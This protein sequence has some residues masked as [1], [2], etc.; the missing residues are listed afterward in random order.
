MRSRVLSAAAAALALAVFSGG[1]TLPTGFTEVSYSGLSNATA[2]A[3]APDGRLFVCQQGGQLRI[4]KNGALLATP[5]V[6]LSVDPMGERGLLGVAFDPNFLLNQYVYVYYTV[7]GSPPHN[8]LARLTA[9]GDV[10]LAGSQVNLLEL[11]NLSGATNHNGG[12]I[13]F[14][15]DGKL[16]VAVGDNANGSNS[17]T[18]GNLLGKVLRVG[19]PPEALIPTDNP[20]FNDTTGNNRA[21]WTLGLRNPF[22]FA[23]H[24]DTGVI[25]INDV[26][27]VTWEEINVG[28]AGANYGWPDCEGDCSPPD[29]EFT[30]PFFFYPHS[31]GA[32]SIAGGDFYAPDVPQ[33]PASYVGKYFYADYCAGWIRYV[34]PASGNPSATTFATGISSPVDVHV[35]F[36]G[37]LYYIARGQGR[38]YKV[39]YTGTGDPVVTE[40]PQS[41]LISTGHPVT[42]TVSATGDAP[43]SYQ[44]QREGA[45][46]GGATS[47]SYTIASVVIGDDG[48]QFRCVV[49][50]ASGDDTSAAATLSVTTNQPPVATITAPPAGTTYAAGDTINYS[51]TGSDPETGALPGSA[52]TWWVNF[53]HDTHFHPFLPPTTGSATGAFTIPTV[54]E[55]SPNVW[56]RL[57][58]SVKDPATLTD[59]K[60]VDVIP[61]TSSLTLG[62]G[63]TGLQLT[64]DGQPFTAPQ[65]VVSVENVTRAIGAPSPQSSGGNT[66]HFQSWSDG[67]SQTHDIATPADDTTYTASFTTA[68]PTNTPTPSRTPTPTR[69]PTRTPTPTPTTTPGGTA[70][71]SIAPTSGAAAGGTPVTVSGSGFASGATLAIGGVPASGVVVVGP[72]SLTASAPALVAGTLNDV[73]VDN[74][75]SAPIGTLANAWFADFSDVPSSNIF[76]GDIESI[77]RASVTAGCGGGNYCPANLVTRAQM[78]VFLL[79]GVHGGGYTPPACSGTVFADVPCPSGLNVDWINQLAAEGITG[80]CGGGN[81]CPGSPLTRAQMAVFLLL[82][83]HGSSYEPPACSGT[84]FDD[85]P[86][87]SGPNVNWINQL[88]AEGITVGCGGG[89]YCPTA[90]TPRGQMSTF[91]VRTFGLGPTARPARPVRRIPGARPPGR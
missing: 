59:E 31:G 24:P 61:R 8:R 56:Y 68:T 82:G 53:H 30:D 27:Q 49:S 66:Y 85:V 89:N 13:H 3:V 12:A 22:T 36:N 63:P 62:T 33:F 38:V 7:P 39:N 10:A 67:G 55:T 23:V 87:P 76:H 40:D 57:Y 58:L 32:C 86:C 52:F 84:V 5:F 44:W 74:P 70:V 73:T 45:D 54:G 81:Y 79:K 25:F 43:L 71:T 80:G 37:N 19:V 78:A 64:L 6:T 26:G 90:A 1:A 18:L 48:D 28:S 88:A 35:D 41:Q 17:Q 50:N 65:T 29:P 20:F 11:N 91:L 69:T 16:Y 2:M 47:S 77:F 60:F 34:D 4:I 9:N 42:F 51:G 75:A 15:A 14:G 83:E 21:I 72:G 46:I